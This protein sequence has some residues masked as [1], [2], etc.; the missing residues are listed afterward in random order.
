MP[1]LRTL[2]WHKASAWAS[3]LAGKSDD[4]AIKV[5]WQQHRF[6]PSCVR[7]VRAVF[8]QYAALDCGAN[9]PNTAVV[10]CIFA[11]LDKGNDWTYAP[12]KCA[13]R[14]QQI[15]VQRSRCMFSAAL[16]VVAVEMVLAHGRGL[17]AR[18][19]QLLIM[20][21]LHSPL[22][23]FA[24]FLRK[25]VADACQCVHD[26]WG[27]PQLDSDWEKTYSFDIWI[28]DGRLQIKATQDA[29]GTDADIVVFSS[30]D[31]R[32][33]TKRCAGTKS[34]KLTFSKASPVRLCVCTSSSRISA[35]SS[36]S[37]TRRRSGKRHGN[38]NFPNKIS[39][40]QPRHP[41]Q[42]RGCWGCAWSGI[43]KNV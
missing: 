7:L 3:Q 21:S 40:Q 6:G 18:R 32:N 35:Q 33:M 1:R 26:F 2:S 31:A 19:C 12:P 15:E 23:Q 42:G 38:S 22:D 8:P 36:T 4:V 27:L 43:V 30:R 39:A 24:A 34:T 25:Y 9:Q 41:M 14:P 5:G 11:D 37:R 29:H 20:W 16:H 10:P 13:A 17:G 28:E